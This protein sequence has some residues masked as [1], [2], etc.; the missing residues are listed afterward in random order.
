MT[1][2]TPIGDQLRIKI[3]VSEYPD[4]STKTMGMPLSRDFFYMRPL[5]SSKVFDGL[6]GIFFRPL[7][8]LFRR[9]AD[10]AEN[11]TRLS[12]G[13]G[14]AELILDQQP[15]AATRPNGVGI[16]ELRRSLFE[17]TLEFVELF[18]VEFRRATGNRLGSESVDALFVDDFSP[19]FDA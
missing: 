14:N 1:S 16:V 4:S 3:G 17:E 19:A 8:R 6:G 15:H 11:A 7:D 18:R 10:L 13:I 5:V 12:F 9:P 2:G